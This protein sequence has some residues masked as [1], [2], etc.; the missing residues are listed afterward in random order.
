[1]DSMASRLIILLGALLIQG[2]VSSAERDLAEMVGRSVCAACH[3]EQAA[4]WTGSHHDLAMQPADNNTVLGDFNNASMTHYG[5]TSTFFKKDGAFMVRTEGPDGSLRDYAIEYTFGVE[6][7][8]QYLIEFPGGRLQALGLAWDTRPEEQGGQRWFHLYPDEKIAHDDELHWTRPGQ[9]WNSMCAECHSTHLRKSYDPAARTFST[10]WSEID[11]S[12]EA[13]HG[14][15]SKHVAWAGHKPGWEALEATKGLVIALDERK[16]VRWTIDPRTGNASRS[17]VRNGAKEIEMCARCHARRS[18]ISKGY[19]H[20]EPFMDHYRPRL[21]DEGLYFSDG[22]IDG[23]VYVY[24]SFLQSR[25][26]QQGVTCSDCHEPH[27]LQL[28]APGNGVCLQCHAAEKYDSAGHHFHKAESRG[29]SCAECHMPPKTYMVVDPRHDHSMRIPRPDLSVQLGTPNACTNC[30][31][32]RS[33]EWATK[34]VKEW[35]GR[36]AQGWQRYAGV[37]RAARDG[38]LDAGRKLAELAQD[39]RT[40]GIARATALAGLGPYLSPET[41]DAIIQ[42]LADDDP[43]LRLVALEALEPLPVAVRARFA[44]PLLHDRVRAV[45]IEAARMLAGIPVADLPAEQRSRLEKGFDEYLQAQQAMAERPEAQLSMGNL[46]AARGMTAQAISAYR[47]AT[48]LDP[49]F[50]PAYVNTAELLRSLGDEA[51]AEA[52]LRR[53]TAVIPDNGDL[54]HALGLSL[55]RQK[56]TEE[57]VEALEQAAR[58][59]PDNARYVYVYA[60]ALSSAGDTGQAI[61]VLQGAHNRF[62]NNTDILNALTAFHRDSGNAG[63]A[64]TYTDK[65]RSLSP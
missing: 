7:L 29:A 36:D 20:G 50:V 10:T 45:R 1:M 48:E 32:D 5:V 23:E 62:P 8:Q 19:V 54:Y 52:M 21:L 51:E 47:T 38:E 43:M 49:A 16:D 33:A 60:V 55:V 41:I 22:Q 15:G 37:L 9:N 63:A 24:G 2:T 17:R 30:H 11:V 27:S 14:P 18:P 34:Q 4:R 31:A 39:S 57:A 46:Y 58:L 26:Y 35:Y 42:G 61:M 53:A 44:F 28:R 64:R 13:C 3:A 6:P 25:M 59:S 40:P 56:R 65:L 12:C